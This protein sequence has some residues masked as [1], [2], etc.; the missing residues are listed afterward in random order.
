MAPLEGN[1]KQG[2]QYYCPVL[3]NIYFSASAFY[4]PLN[5]VKKQTCSP[6]NTLKGP[7]QA[8]HESYSFYIGFIGGCLRIAVFRHYWKCQT[9]WSPACISFLSAF[10]N[11][12][13]EW[14][15]WFCDFIVQNW[16]T[17]LWITRV[18]SWLWWG[19]WKGG[20]STPRVCSELLSGDREKLQN[21]ATKSSITF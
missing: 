1:E 10:Q 16:K 7:S 17:F 3:F 8:A 14:R 4:I 21:L 19:V 2:R 20:Y 9:W 13:N 6:S 18:P 12:R 11:E 15:V 5:F